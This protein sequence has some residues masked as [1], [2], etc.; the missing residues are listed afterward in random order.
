MPHA[1]PIP[2]LSSYIRVEV[3]DDENR[4]QNVD[5]VD[6]GDTTEDEDRWMVDTCQMRAFLQINA[7]QRL[8]GWL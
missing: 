1:S 8:S 7:R 6:G 3:E 2:S 4:S 5:D